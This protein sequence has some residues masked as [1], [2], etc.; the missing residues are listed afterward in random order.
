MPKAR[1][2]SPNPSNI[3][4]KPDTTS[5]RGREAGT[6]S[7]DKSGKPI[8]SKAY[9]EKHGSGKGA[10]TAQG[11]SKECMEPGCKG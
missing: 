7:R 11:S 10:G 1:S 5:L 6:S 3:S 2:I 4:G 8:G 9:R